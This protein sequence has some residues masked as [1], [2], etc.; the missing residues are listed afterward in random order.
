MIKTPLPATN[1]ALLRGS[2]FTFTQ[3]T[4]EKPVWFSSMV[5][6]SMLRHVTFRPF[7]SGRK[8]KKSMISDARMSV[9][10]CTEL[11]AFCGSAEV[12]VPPYRIGKWACS[13]STQTWITKGTA[14]AA[15]SKHDFMLGGNNGFWTTKIN[16]PLFSTNMCLLCN[17]VCKRGMYMYVW[18]CSIPTDPTAQS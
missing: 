16:M 12:P 14:W 8:Y 4:Q 6:C 9:H 1:T 10:I 7:L 17:S 18:V 2:C 11:Y 13:A 15:S 3:H 5:P